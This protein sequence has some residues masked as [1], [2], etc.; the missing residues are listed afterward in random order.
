MTI[1]GSFVHIYVNVHGKYFL[2]VLINIYFNNILNKKQK[3]WLDIWAQT[4]AELIRTIFI[5]KFLT[6]IVRI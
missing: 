4:Y 6:F 1:I 3:N 2:K 5:E